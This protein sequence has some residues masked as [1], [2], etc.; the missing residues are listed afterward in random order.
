MAFNAIAN[1]TVQKSTD[2]I[3]NMLDTR[4]TRRLSTMVFFRPK[5]SATTPDGISKQELTT[6]KIL[7]IIPISR[8][9]NPLSASNATQDAPAI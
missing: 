3:I 7:S 2:T 4:L 9:E 5:T 6:W 8:S 1:A